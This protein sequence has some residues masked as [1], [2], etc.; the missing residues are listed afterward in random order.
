MGLLEVVLGIILKDGQVL[1]VK[2]TKQDI[3]KDGQILNWGFPGGKIEP[4]E[5]KEAA[6]VREIYEETGYTVSIERFLS[7]R[8]HPDHPVHVSYFQCALTSNTPHSV[9]DQGTGEIQWVAAS[10]VQS[11]MT[12]PLDR[13]VEEFLANSSIKTL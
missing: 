11:F 6:V 3:G 1:L 8:T 9:T 12:S 4:G 10:S 7:E 2:R 5:S 13:T